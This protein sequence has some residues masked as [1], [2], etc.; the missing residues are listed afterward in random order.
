MARIIYGV[1]GEG[2]GHAT[3]SRPIL[4]HLTKKHDVKIFSSGKA[5]KYLSNNFKGVNE[6]EGLF[7]KYRDNAVNEVWTVLFNIS[8]TFKIIGSIKKVMKTIDRFKP[9]IVISD[10]DIVAVYA[11]FLKGIPVIN[12]DNQHICGK[13]EIDFPKRLWLNYVQT[14]IVNKLAVPYAKYYFVTTFFY[15]KTMSK[16]VFLFP[17]ILRD[18]ISG[19]KVKNR[20]YILVYQTS[21]SN[22][23]LIKTLKEI[24]ER[25]IV[26]GFDMEK[27]DKNITFRKFID[28]RFFTELR[29]CRAI[30]TNGGFTLMTEAI[31]LEKPVLSIPVK[32]QFEQTTNAI[33]LE[34]LGYGR[35][36]KYAT[37]EIIIDFI[38]NLGAY[39]K[40]LKKYRKEDNSGI[41]KELDSII[42]D[43]SS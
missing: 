36:A 12:I 21:D 38:N 43:V 33:Y 34:R 1:C 23:K 29:E 35:Y 22:K 26:Y 11:A 27:R 19:M 30:I 17:P 16:D 31:H 18:E 14:R 32:R 5:L 9:D 42:S 20:D 7:M 40:N 10:Y 25:F 41:L 24:D 13:T 3:R 2:M 4:E 39:K 28:K 8:N 15:P 6:I 37:Y